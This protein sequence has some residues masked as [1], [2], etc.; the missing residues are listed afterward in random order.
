MNPLA[1]AWMRRHWP[2]TGAIVVLILFSVVHLAV[3][4]P[5]ARRYRTTLRLATEL[6]MPL[7]P[8]QTPPVLPPRVFALLSDNA[9]PAATVLERGNSG[10]LVSELIED[11]ARIGGRHGLQVVVTEP[12]T[13]TQ[14]PG[15]TQVRA[16][17]H[18]RGS[19]PGFVALLGE[20][21]SGGRLFAVDRFTISSQEPGRQMFEIWISRLILKQPGG[22]R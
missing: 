18:L 3:F 14:L 17:L 21:A 10:T 4:E 9:L 13:A 6:G 8:E 19:Y 2:L 20:L 22:R 16:H 5:A 11:V 15:S 1:A 7:E 12:G